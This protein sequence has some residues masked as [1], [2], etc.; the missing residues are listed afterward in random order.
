MEQNPC[1]RTAKPMTDAS[2]GSPV[3]D[4]RGWADHLIRA[5][6]RGPGDTVDAAIHRA[7][8]KHRLDP[9]TLWRLR[10]R[11]PKD[12]LASV[13]LTLKAA[14]EA[15]CAKQEAKLRHELEITKALPATEAR[16][17]LIAETEALL[18]S[19]EGEAGRESA[20]RTD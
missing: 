9:R 19:L 3:A 2:I 7:A 15:E 12:M 16:I 1:R 17:A 11:A 13:Y 5:S 10:Y 8:T 18:R 4:A 20:E 6:H 14:Y